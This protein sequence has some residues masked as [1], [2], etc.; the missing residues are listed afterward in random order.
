MINESSNG[1]KGSWKSEELNLLNYK[2]TYT[3]NHHFLYLN[4]GEKRGV[5]DRK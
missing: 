5:T 2:F 4:V 1:G 3:V